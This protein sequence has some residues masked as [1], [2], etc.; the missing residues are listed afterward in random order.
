M[1]I[2]LVKYTKV[3]EPVGLAE[4][5]V[6]VNGAEIVAGWYEVD[7]DLHTQQ[8]TLLPTRTEGCPSLR[9]CCLQRINAREKGNNNCN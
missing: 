8:V 1:A 4:I 7:V 5:Q 2:S 3:I 6:R 9:P